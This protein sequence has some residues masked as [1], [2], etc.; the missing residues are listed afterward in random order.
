MLF[1][2]SLLILLLR[3][4]RL[5]LIFVAQLQTV[6]DQEGTFLY[7]VVVFIG[8]GALLDYFCISRLRESQINVD[9]RLVYNISRVVHKLVDRLRSRWRA[10]QPVAVYIALN[11]N[12]K[13]THT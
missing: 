10:M 5:I 12:V 6:T 3:R 4:E 13:R 1:I 7:F 2:L 8:A 9:G 11:K